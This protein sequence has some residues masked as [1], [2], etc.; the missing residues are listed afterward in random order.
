MIHGDIIT[1][2]PALVADVEAAMSGVMANAVAVPQASEAP[3]LVEAVVEVEQEPST[4]SL[5]E[6]LAEAKERLAAAE[7]ADLRSRRLGSVAVI[8]GPAQEHR[9]EAVVDALENQASLSG[10]LFIGAGI[11]PAI[12]RRPAG[13]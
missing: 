5:S 3:V 2:D 12:L 13:L 6:Q 7:R 10:A 8:L 9:A 1:Q 4:R 11:L